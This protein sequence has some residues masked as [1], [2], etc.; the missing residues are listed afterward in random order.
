MK[1][2]LLALALLFCLSEGNTQNV[3]TN[4]TNFTDVMGEEILGYM[5]NGIPAGKTFTFRYRPDKFDGYPP[6]VDSI[7]HMQQVFNQHNINLEVIYTAEM[8]TTSAYQNYLA[9]LY[10][11]SNGVNII[12]I[13]AGNETYSKK[14]C[15][16][17]WSC[18]EEPID[19]IRAFLKGDPLTSSIPIIY[20]VAP[21]PNLSD[22]ENPNNS[23]DFWNNPLFNYVSTKAGT[24]DDLYAHL[25]FNKSTLPILADLSQP[26]T[27]DYDPGVYYPSL[28]NFFTTMYSQAIFSLYTWDDMIA[29]M[30]RSAPDRDIHITEFGT[31]NSSAYKNTLAYSSI[32]WELMTRYHNDVANMLIH[33]GPAPTGAGIITPASKWDIG[34]GEYIRRLDWRM[35]ELFYE[36][37]DE[38]QLISDYVLHEG[39]NYLTYSTMS[40]YN[41][42]IYSQPGYHITDIYQK[43][44]TGN[45]SYSGSGRA[46]WWGKQ[47]TPCLEVDK[48]YEV[49]YA[50]WVVNIPKGFG[51]LNVTVAA[52]DVLGCTDPSAINYNP[53]ATVDDASCIYPE[54]EPECRRR[55]MWFFCTKSKNRCNC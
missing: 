21:K 30:K 11:V 49:K 48:P 18:I 6:D 37:P 19:E 5:V 12:G 41:T 52:D 15:N 8:L 32:L 24:E 26:E 51:Y 2:I 35:L 39:D 31:S 25:Y 46:E 44:Y 9:I 13:E 20:P 27:V 7:V 33:N 4:G 42:A 14:Q 50:S 38:T 53:A 36:L 54:P 3:G 10:L 47:S 34:D 22:I 40:A 16:F 29:Y 55:F 17:T 1:Q 45:Y 43:G 28:D 23:H